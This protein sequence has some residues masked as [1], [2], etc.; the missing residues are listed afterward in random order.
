M[1]VTRS[2]LSVLLHAGTFETRSRA[3]QVHSARTPGLRCHKVDNGRQG[4]DDWLSI[5]SC[6]S[7]HS[8]FLDSSSSGST[9]LFN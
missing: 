6:A 4:Q 8:A 7:G 5:C 1:H 3:Q 2:P 9:K